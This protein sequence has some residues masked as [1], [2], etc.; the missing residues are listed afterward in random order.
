VKHTTHVRAPAEHAGHCGATAR[1]AARFAGSD[2]AHR[3]VAMKRILSLSALAVFT[4]ALAGCATVTDSAGYRVTP[5]GVVIPD[6]APP[7]AM[8]SKPVRPPWWPRT[9][10]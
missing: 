7:A 1:P 9:R 8:D 10:P 6:A 5:R 3:E 4:A 2:T